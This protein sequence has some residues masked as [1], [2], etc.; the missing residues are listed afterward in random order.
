[1]KACKF[2]E[3]GGGRWGL[4]GSFPQVPSTWQSWLDWNSLQGDF[5]AALAEALGSLV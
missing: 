2:R 1:M 5:R 4:G 3:A